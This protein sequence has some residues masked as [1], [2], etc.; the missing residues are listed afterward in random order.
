M[1]VLFVDDE[2]LIAMV[3]EDALRDAG[4]D[5]MTA[6]DAPAA[7]TLLR[8]HPRKFTAL[9]SDYHMPGELNGVD[10][11]EHTLKNYPGIPAIV[12]TGRPDV[13]KAGWLAGH[14]VELLTKPYTPEALVEMVERLLHR[15]H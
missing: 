5:V 7:V 11:I 8:Q 2:P 10:L 1:C 12:A 14:G 15:P 13:I 9:I 3:V 4:H 6:S